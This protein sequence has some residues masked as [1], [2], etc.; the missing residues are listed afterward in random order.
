MSVEGNLYV[1]LPGGTHCLFDHKKGK[2]QSSNSGL[3]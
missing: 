3:A 2:Y 1:L